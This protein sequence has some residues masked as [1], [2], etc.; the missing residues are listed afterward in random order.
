MVNKHKKSSPSKREPEDW[1]WNLANE[2]LS[3]APRKKSWVYILI[4][5]LLIGG[6]LSLSLPE[7]QILIASRF[8][9]M[10]DNKR[11]SND[12]IVTTAKPA[13]VFIEASVINGLSISVHQGTGFNISP[14]GKII[15]N[16]HIIK[17]SNNIKVTFGDGK[18]FY[19]SHFTTIEGVDLAVIDLHSSNLPVIKVDKLGLPQ[20]GQEVTIIGNPLG[21]Q[22]IAQRGKVGQYHMSNGNDIEVFD[23]SVPANPGNSGS[24]VL[25]DKAQVVGIVFASSEIKSGEQSQNHALAIPIT[26]LP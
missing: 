19:V 14:Q 12:Q 2:E 8:D 7:L 20:K 24:P 5:L 22:K 18:A 1:E 17:G 16:R 3:T 13:V 9:F 10:A 21:L 23:I 15:T 25:N 26:A 4:T 11:L 6:F